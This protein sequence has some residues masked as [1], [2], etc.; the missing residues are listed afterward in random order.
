MNRLDWSRQVN[1]EDTTNFNMAQLK[2]QGINIANQISFIGIIIKIS[3][4]W[5]KLTEISFYVKK[6]GHNFQDFWN[7]RIIKSMVYQQLLLW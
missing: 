1:R 6:M 7:N 3:A 5:I 4:L 2:I